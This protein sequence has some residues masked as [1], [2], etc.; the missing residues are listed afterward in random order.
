MPVLQ[1][2]QNDGLY[3]EFDRP[4]RQGAPT[5][6]F[7]NAIT[8]D[9]SMWQA[10][11]APALREAGFGTLC[12]NFRGQANSPYSADLNLDEA[13]IAG[14]LQH[15]VEALKVDRPVL[16]GLSIGGL[17]AAKA[18]LNGLPVAGLVLINT[19][20]RIG[21]R[22]AWMNDATLR[23]MQVAGPN[24]MRDAMTPLLSGPDFLTAHRSE[25]LLPDATYEPL[26]ADSGAINLVTWMGK[27]DWDIA[28]DKLDCPTLVMTG[29]HDRVFYDQETVEELFAMLPKGRR[30]DVAEAGHMLPVEA[31]E[32][33][34]AAVIEFANAL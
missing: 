34:C 28:Y 12:Y 25:F 16:V 10:V 9:V 18:V 20:R 30:V 7:V 1:L 24:L 11:V 3:Y 26:P 22:I 31:P 29:P 32:A 5:F 33:F 19:L 14:D 15:I 4:T 13:V 2:G 6:V 21:P 23:I 17:Y 8:G 27:T